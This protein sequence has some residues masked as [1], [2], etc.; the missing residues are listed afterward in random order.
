[1]KLVAA[2]LRCSWAEAEAIVGDVPTEVGFGSLRSRLEH[3][4]A[5]EK[6]VA[7][8]AQTWLPSIRSIMSRG[9][10]A[11]FWRYLIK[12]GFPEPELPGLIRY[13]HLRCSSSG[14]FRNRLCIPILTGEGMVGWTGRAILP[15]MEPRYLAY[16]DSQ[17]KARVFNEWRVRKGGRVLVIVEGPLDC[18]KLDW[19]GRGVGLRSVALMGTSATDAQVGRL[20][21][22]TE[23]FASTAILLDPG[24]AG[25][26]GVLASKLAMRSPR[27]LSF[28]SLPARFSYADDPG[29]LQGRDVR[30][31]LRF[32]LRDGI[33]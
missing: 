18:L 3:E 6:P 13:Y 20:L 28:D 11:A 27:L 17:V 14:Q 5:S 21:G 8:S 25:A 31:A 23:G 33:R 1:M 9:P 32:L 4:S 22:M 2:L 10:R 16:P 19:F 7:V 26:A 24:A 30:S 15:G 29:A 12:R